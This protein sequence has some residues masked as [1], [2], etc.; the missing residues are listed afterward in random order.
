MPELLQ[1][2]LI[3][4]AVGAFAGVMA[5]LLGIGGG[6]V[7]V[8]ALAWVFHTQGVDD[9]IVMHLALGTSLATIVFTSVS[10]VRAHHRRGAVLWEPVR[11]LAPGIVVGAWL[12]AQIADALPTA[13]LKLVFAIFV[14]AVSAQIAL[15]AQPAGQHRLP[16]RV[17]MALTGGLIG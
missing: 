10:S 7:I 9:G 14:L 4:L 3:C 11:R 1:T 16:G 12:G 2:L 5:G 13:T 6:L 15:G 17:G 8:P